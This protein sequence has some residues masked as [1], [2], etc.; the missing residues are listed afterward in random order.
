MLVAGVALVVLSRGPSGGVNADRRDHTAISRGYHVVI[1][2]DGQRVCEMTT[3]RRSHRFLIGPAMTGMGA[4][5]PLAVA[6]A[7]ERNP[8]S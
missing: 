1:D 7:K 8:P 4:T 5:S 6:S 2:Q 3:I